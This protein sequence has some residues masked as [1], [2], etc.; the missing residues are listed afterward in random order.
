M[1]EGVG[2]KVKYRTLPMSVYDSRFTREKDGRMRVERR[3]NGDAERERE[4]FLLSVSGLP[5]GGIPLRYTSVGPIYRAPSLPP[6]PWISIR[7]G[8]ANRG[9]KMGEEEW[10][11]TVYGPISDCVG[12]VWFRY[13][14]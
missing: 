3:S 2:D 9:G 5:T 7:R 13:R 12:P 14:S 11:L 10:L 1:A 6:P 8:V 4:G